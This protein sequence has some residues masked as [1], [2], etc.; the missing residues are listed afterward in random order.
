[1]LYIQTRIRRVFERVESRFVRSRPGSVLILVVVLLVLMAMLGTAYLV[2]ARN[3]RVATRIYQHNV[4]IDMLVDAVIN[5]AE[6]AVSD[7]P[8]PT[9]PTAGA[10]TVPS[11]QL[12]P[13][14]VP[15]QTPLAQTTSP[16]A[17]TFPYPS[18]QP[19]FYTR[20]D[21]WTAT[22]P[23][24]T[25]YP[26]QTVATIVPGSYYMSTTNVITPITTSVGIDKT[27]LASRYPV[28]LGDAVGLASDTVYLGGGLVNPLSVTQPQNPLAAY[29]ATSWQYWH[30]MPFPRGG[31]VTSGGTTY[32][33]T[34]DNN[35]LPPT[36]NNNNANATAQSTPN[37]AG[38]TINPGW[39]AIG[40][41]PTLVTSSSSGNL[42][43]CVWPAVS[44]PLAVG[45]SFEDP[46]YTFSNDTPQGDVRA[47]LANTSPG[48]YGMRPDGS[49]NYVEPS[50]VTIGGINY[51]ALTYFSLVHSRYEKALAASASGDGIADAFLWR[52]PVS[53]VDGITYYAATRIVDNNS[54]INVNTANG[55]FTDFYSDGSST[56][57][58]TGFEPGIFPSG[59]GLEDIL[60]TKPNPLSRANG[61]Y[62]MTDLS[63]EMAAVNQYR[64]RNTAWMNQYYTNP[65]A[66]PPVW[67]STPM[68]FPPGIY[69]RT[70]NSM[71]FDDTLG[72]NSSGATVAKPVARSDFLY[73]TLGDALWHG[74]GSRLSYPG[75][76]STTTQFQVFDW[77][78]AAA[79]A[80]K[81]DLVNANAAPSNVEQVFTASTLIPLASSATFPSTPWD[82]GQTQTWFHNNF[83]EDPGPPN[84]QIRRAFLTTHNPVSN[85]I[86]AHSLYNML[87]PRDTNGFALTGASGIAD[88]TPPSFTTAGA[89]S[90]S[91]KQQNQDLQTLMAGASFPAGAAASYNYATIKNPVVN[92]AAPADFIPAIPK[93]SL[94]TSDVTS[95]D[96]SLTPVTPMPLTGYPPPN[97]L[98]I[99][100]LIAAGL[101]GAGNAT[102]VKGPS[103]WLGFYNAMIDAVAPNY[104]PAFS[105]TNTPYVYGQ[106]QHLLPA[107]GEAIPTMSLQQTASPRPGQFRSPL[108][109]V[110]YPVP[111]ANA[112]SYNSNNYMDG[113]Q[114]V[115]LRSL[116]AAVNAKDLRDSDDD[117]THVQA[118]IYPRLA[119]GAVAP[120][121]SAPNRPVLAAFINATYSPVDVHVYGIEKQPF[122]TEVYVNTEIVAPKMI[123]TKSGTPTPNTNTKKNTHGYVAVQLYNPYDVPIDMTNW[124]LGIMNRTVGAGPVMTMKSISGF[125]GFATSATG[126]PVIPPKG[127]LLLENYSPTASS[128][129]D[130]TY[131]PWL[132][133]PYPTA[134]NPVSYYV[135]NLHEVLTVTGSESSTGNELYLLRQLPANAVGAATNQAINVLPPVSLTATA[136][137]TPFTYLQMTQLAPVD[138][139]DFSG[140]TLPAGLANQPFAA[141]FHYV[142][143]TTPSAAYN[144]RFV[145]PGRWSPYKYFVTSSITA[146]GVIKL[147]QEG[148][149]VSVWNTTSGATGNS[150][151]D[152]WNYIPPGPGCLSSPTNGA[153]T[154]TTSASFQAAN[155][156]PSPSGVAS[157][158]MTAYSNYYLAPMSFGVTTVT[159]GTVVAKNLNT[160]CSYVNNFPAIQLN[161]TD[162]GGPSKVN[163]LNKAPSAT[164]G[165]NLMFPFGGFARV[166]DVLQVPYIGSY[167]ILQPPPGA[168]LVPSSP[169]TPPSIAYIYEINPVTTDSSFADD[170]DTDE[171]IAYKTAS[172][173]PD[174]IL[175]SDDAIEQVGRFC[176]LTAADPTNATLQIYPTLGRPTAVLPM[177]DTYAWANHVFDYFTAIGNPH[178]DY[179]PNVDPNSY[180]AGAWNASTV[181]TDPAYHRYSNAGAA[182]LPPNVPVP[183]SGIA[184]NPP[185]G[186]TA[187]TQ[188][189]ASHEDTAGVEG[190]INV[191][192]ASIYVLQRVPWNP[193]SNGPVGSDEPTRYQVN[194]N[195]ARNIVAYRN[196]YGPFK[197][198]FDLN[199]VPGLGN[200]I[201][202]VNASVTLQSLY[203]DPATIDFT[204][205]FGD[206]SPFAHP[207]APAAP[208]ST[209]NVTNDFET[210]FGTIIRLSNI[211]TTR[212][213]TFTAYILVQGWSGVGTPTPTLVVQRR[214]AM[215]L[216][217][218]AL[219]ATNQ[220]LNITVVPTN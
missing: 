194:Q 84:R 28:A 109:D 100:T 6:S 15:A 98:N 93:I 27:W 191:N 17:Y 137:P 22:G 186:A 21:D 167:M 103:L 74:I 207:G 190:L 112:T 58:D 16:P 99:P 79:L 42:T 217:R 122:I 107:I 134:M 81:F 9:I 116:I 64:M 139:F 214:A 148:I 102:P 61:P 135:P 154:T 67:P 111:A 165:S 1:M 31:I 41:F 14:P 33:S 123:Q 202:G 127:F 80:Y 94:N 43:P 10:S 114:V 215:I 192:T 124:T 75:F 184:L 106:S 171:V 155:P 170:N 104:G 183:Q 201:L 149:A 150:Q 8:A 44:G 196:T 185:P 95:Q 66:Y 50:W 153:A 205:P 211:L 87:W 118:A 130:A 218:S 144:W 206:L 49:R 55:M 117:V 182:Y 156:D 30:G 46:R 37:G 52:L 174:A 89:L 62:A 82:P 141:A 212:S 3:D 198:L 163:T 140:M 133:Y 209:D 36:S 110:N 77:S 199:K 60:D 187:G 146:A 125:A 208:S 160:G 168:M 5:L 91:L 51:P 26:P 78:D 143:S 120:S 158:W 169:S 24:S 157:P 177:Q 216:D 121:Q 219:T 188:I 113:N 4:Q 29:A 69:K 18:N 97:N 35:P 19:G 7:L 45:A 179:T 159:T 161:N 138:M 76:L 172:G 166:G 175:P 57:A 88:Y 56:D 204:P 210:R 136:S 173:N 12:A 83:G 20:Y 59:M 132:S 39:V 48:S 152:N 129:N 220:N 147:R 23:I 178:D 2:T 73:R 54:A 71:P 164:G 40:S 38:S 25:A 105:Q 32:M 203:A 197:T 193:A 200:S 101:P 72:Q 115:L 96:P 53:A 180:S 126:N 213:D 108:R 68:I 92:T 181:A 85:L 195:I 128:G 65:S 86:P 70:D 189:N 11:S 162:F 90:T 151:Y 119:S 13:A 63:I 47:P 142:R 176:P 34:V 131:R 145:Y